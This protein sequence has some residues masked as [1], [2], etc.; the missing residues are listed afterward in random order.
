MHRR[1]GQ[2]KIRR[3]I[4][5]G[6]CTVDP[7]T[8]RAISFSHSVVPFRR[9]PQMHLLTRQGGARGSQGPIVAAWFV[10]VSY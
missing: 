7:K 6:R 10:T 9:Q 8:H 4:S 5:H 1:P 2:L 3:A